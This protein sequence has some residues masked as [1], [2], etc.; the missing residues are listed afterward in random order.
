MANQ[1]EIRSS[2]RNTRKTMEAEVE[3]NHAPEPMWMKL[4]GERTPR[5]DSPSRFRE[6]SQEHEGDLILKGTK[7]S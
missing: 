2:G 4:C 7:V 1:E 5:L 3:L 6:R